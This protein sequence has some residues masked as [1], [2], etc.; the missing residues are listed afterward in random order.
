MIIQIKWIVNQANTSSNINWQE[1]GK[2]FENETAQAIV[3]H[4]ATKLLD[5][6]DV[7]FLTAFGPEGCVLLEM[8]ARLISSQE[9]K[10][11]RVATSLN[12]LGAK[13]GKIAI[14]NLDTGYQFKETLE[15][16]KQLE[17]KYGLNIIMVEPELTV[18]EQ[19]TSYG[20]RLYERDPD[21]C[22]YMRKLKPLSKLLDNRLAWISSIRRDQTEVRANA[23]SFEFDRKFKLGKVN[24]LIKW[25][26]SDIWKY[27]HENK[28]PYNPLLDL[29]Y[30]SIG[31]EPCTSPGTDRK[32]SRWA[33]K[34]KIEC[35]LHIQDEEQ[36]QGGEF[37][38]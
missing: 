8:L 14:A 20:A 9:L 28:I 38:I 27:I 13:Q 30:E 12:E 35:G 24:P 29:G 3:K 31:C 2:A 10:A 5:H 11:D 16:K 37:V 19:D 26:K 23:M 21:Q 17:A 1:L 6:G 32:G 25:S 22:C 18:P 34:D 7:I 4:A 15:L 33:G 36:A